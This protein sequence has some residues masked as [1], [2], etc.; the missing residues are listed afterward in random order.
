MSKTKTD[1]LC[2]CG[3]QEPYSKC[4]GKLHEGSQ[5][6]NALKLMRSRYSA[7][8]KGRDDYIM[9]TTHPLNPRFDPDKERWSKSILEFSRQTKFKKLDIVE[10]IDGA[11]EAYV[12]F[13]AHMEQGGQPVQLVEKSRFEKIDGKWLY[14]SG[15]FPDD[16]QRQ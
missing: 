4:C 16:G 13:I 8:A 2:P 1:E 10:F 6:E 15:V 11:D 5:A 9:R 14:H 7:Y 12:S 3:S